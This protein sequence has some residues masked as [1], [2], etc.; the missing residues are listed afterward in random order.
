MK[1]NVML[2]LSKKVHDLLVDYGLTSAPY[3]VKELY[4]GQVFELLSNGVSSIAS[5]GCSFGELGAP[6]AAR[7]LPHV[8]WS[9]FKYSGD[10]EPSM[11]N[12]DLR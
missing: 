11:T 6:I 2:N 7:S 12:A 1:F 9:L 8:I 3:D 10:G 5:V 4:M